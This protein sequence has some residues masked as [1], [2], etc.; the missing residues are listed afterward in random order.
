MPENEDDLIEKM[1]DA[2]DA[3][4]A[5]EC[6]GKSGRQL[7]EI[8]A[9]A[10]LAIAKPIICD[11]A[12]NEHLEIADKLPAQFDA[13]CAENSE[14]LKEPVIISL[15]YDINLLPEQGRTFNSIKMMR[16]LVAVVEHFKMAR[17][18]ALGE[19]KDLVDALHALEWDSE[20]RAYVYGFMQAVVDISEGISD[21]KSKGQKP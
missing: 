16:Y 7:C 5:P 8:F 1:A 9:R 3:I 21:L 2:I 20:D 12:I 10:A 14:A 18:E 19:A 13:W 4:P 11:E 17:E 15:L 6:R